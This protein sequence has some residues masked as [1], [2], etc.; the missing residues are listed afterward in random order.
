MHSSGHTYKCKHHEDNFADSHAEDLGLQ[1]RPVHEE[2]MEQH[3][4][5][6]QRSGQEVHDADI[7]I[8]KSKLEYYQQ[9]AKRACQSEEHIAAHA[10]ILRER[11]INLNASRET[12]CA[13]PYR[14]SN[15]VTKAIAELEI[16]ALL[17]VAE[18]ERKYVKKLLLR[19]SKA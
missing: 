2:P 1:D 18:V 6:Q 10:K 9:K 5:G 12:L 8:L 7:A 4:S 17:K 15:G 14:T 13:M 16:N 19:K 11:N 3:K